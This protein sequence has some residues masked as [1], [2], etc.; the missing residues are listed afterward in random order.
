MARVQ[1]LQQVKRLAATYLANDDA[2]GTMTQRGPQQVATRD[3]GRIR[4]RA[5][6][7]EPDH[8]RVREL[9]FGGVLNEDDAVRAW[10]QPRERIE[11]RRL[12]RPSAAADQDVVVVRQ[13]TPYEIHDVRGDHPHLDQF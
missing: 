3:R 8:V 5:P 9:E 13:C 2:V 11:Q 4:L 7:L 6:G 10:K 1:R 12:S